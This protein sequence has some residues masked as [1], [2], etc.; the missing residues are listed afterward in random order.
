MKVE[1]L[2]CDVCNTEQKEV[3]HWFVVVA[4]EP[5]LIYTTPRSLSGE[6]YDCCGQACLIKKV[7]ELLS[8]C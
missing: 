2:I 1:R 5:I 8:K 3:N 7:S 4:G 6:S